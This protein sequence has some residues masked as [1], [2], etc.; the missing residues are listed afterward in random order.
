MHLGN[1]I[2]REN[3]NRIHK[4]KKNQSINAATAAFIYQGYCILS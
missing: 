4:K 2:E 3:L 1:V